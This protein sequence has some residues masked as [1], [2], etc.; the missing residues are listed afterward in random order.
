MFKFKAAPTLT[1]DHEVWKLAPQLTTELYI[2]RVRVRIHAIG[3]PIA[4]VLISDDYFGVHDLLGR[5]SILTVDVQ[6]G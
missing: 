6:P 1:N 2:K 3:L 4:I 5:V